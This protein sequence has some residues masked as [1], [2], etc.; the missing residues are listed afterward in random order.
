MFHRLGGTTPRSFRVRTWTHSH[1]MYA[2][3]C[4]L[5][6]GV[7][8]ACGSNPTESQRQAVASKSYT[9]IQ[10]PNNSFNVI[11]VLHNEGLDY[12]ANNAGSALPSWEELQGLVSEYLIEEVGVGYI[13]SAQ[14]TVWYTLQNLQFVRDSIVGIAVSEYGDSLATW[15]EYVSFSP[16]QQAFIYAILGEAEAIEAPISAGKR[17]SA[18]AVFNQI[19]NSILGSTA[20]VGEKKNV[21]LA[22]V[23]VAKHSLEYW[24]DYPEYYDSWFEEEGLEKVADRKKVKKVV[25]EDA[26][27]MIFGAFGG[28]WAGLIGGAVTGGLVGGPAGAAGGAATGAIGGSITG[29]IGGA[30]GYSLGEASK[31]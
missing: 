20:L 8:S 22:L 1:V 9:A 7:V 30:I 14:D 17:D 6:A 13:G 5:L 19:E 27:G 29:A 15:G 31:K 21:P 3:F 23:A 26:K 28:L 18:M 11:G 4:L 12:V 10:N 16:E 2:L 24:S 25:Y